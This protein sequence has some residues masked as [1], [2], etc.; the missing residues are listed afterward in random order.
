M[1]IKK[2][3]YAIL[4]VLMAIIAIVFLIIRNY[5]LSTAQVVMLIITANIL[6]SAVF[7]FIFH[8]NNKQQAVK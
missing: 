2:Y 8:K 1:F 5:S 4:M 6:F 7:L 3:L